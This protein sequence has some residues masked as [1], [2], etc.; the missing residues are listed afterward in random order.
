MLSA[1]TNAIAKIFVGRPSSSPFA[2]KGRVCLNVETMEERMVPS[3][4]PMS[5]AVP[6]AVA[7][8]KVR[9]TAPVAPTI[10]GDE[11]IQV[12]S[13]QAT[14]HASGKRQHEPAI[15]QSDEKIIPISPEQP[16][17]GYKWR[18]RPRPVT[19][20]TEQV[21]TKSPVSVEGSTPATEHIP[22]KALAHVE[23]A[24]L[25]PSMKIEPETESMRL[26]MAMDRTAKF[27]ET[28]S[29]LE[30]QVSATQDSMIQSIK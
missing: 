3:T 27:M 28:L 26:Q 15:A 17:H 19:L 13:D 22:T 7:P 10:K 14:G 8:A 24:E 21:A 23:G 2:L 29:S 25:T 11:I 16:V 1:I 4:T 9:E 5:L 30:K 18:P 20:A 12:K 6:I